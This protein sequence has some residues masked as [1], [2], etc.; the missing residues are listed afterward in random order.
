LSDYLC[1]YSTRHAGRCGRPATWNGRTFRC[2]FH[3]IG[4]RQTGRTLTPPAPP[5]R[6][7]TRNGGPNPF[8]PA[9]SPRN[10]QG[11]TKPQPSRHW[12]NSAPGTPIS[13]AFTLCGVRKG[14]GVVMTTQRRL[15]GC[16]D[17]RRIKA[18]HAAA[19]RARVAHLIGP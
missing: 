19:A 4:A 6:P 12:P 10:T 16:P 11:M 18:G 14:P 17:C 5:P 8:A 2:D 15:I 13:G 3:A 1:T 7:E 9:P